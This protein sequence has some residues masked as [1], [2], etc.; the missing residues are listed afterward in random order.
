MK[1]YVYVL[2]NQAMPGLLKIGRSKAGGQR[3]GKQIYS[4]DT[5]TPLPFELEFECFFYDCVDAE[6][7]VHYDL[8]AYRVNANRE[9]FR[10]DLWQAQKAVL[11]ASAE[12]LGCIVADWEYGLRISDAA[13]HR[14]CDYGE[15]VAPPNWREILA[16]VS[17]EEARPAWERVKTRLEQRL[18][19]LAK[20]RVLVVPEASQ[21][22][23]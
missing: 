21:S 5:G 1:G 11:K 7:A 10:V 16:E 15:E 17:S 4:G 3:R 8:N 22:E 13:V 18:K 2:S 6:A 12:S 23:H 14:N 19:A 9:F 20:R